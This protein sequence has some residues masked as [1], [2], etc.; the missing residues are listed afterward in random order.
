[1]NRLK[2]LQKLTQTPTEL[3]EDF[4]RKL[5]A[6]DIDFLA[7]LLHTFKKYTP[8]ELKKHV[9]SV[10]RSKTPRIA[11]S[12]MI[13]A[14]IETGGAFFDHL[15]NAGNAVVDMAKRA[16]TA[17]ANTA[18]N[19]YD[20]AVPLVQKGLDAAKP[21]VKEYGPNLLGTAASFTPVVGPLLGPVVKKG[22][23]WGFKKLFGGELEG[24]DFMRF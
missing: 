6:E 20:K 21:Y 15:K 11:K 2:K 3:G 24:D 19:F 22:A 10:L 5:K 8:T 12:R 23:E 9:S 13:E 7:H 17:V 4:I 16:G 1:M 18:S 14:H